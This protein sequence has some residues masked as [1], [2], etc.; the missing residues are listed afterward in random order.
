MMF[1]IWRECAAYRIERNAHGFQGFGIVDIFDVAEWRHFVLPLCVQA[2]R[3]V[4]RSRRKRASLSLHSTLF[5]NIVSPVGET[6]LGTQF[7]KSGHGRFAAGAF[8]GSVVPRA[9]LHDRIGDAAIKS[10]CADRAA[11][12]E[13]PPNSPATTVR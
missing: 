4:P 5:V 6:N 2:P 13:P 8:D 10:T 9:P 7:P 11:A 1:Q 12:T 3:L